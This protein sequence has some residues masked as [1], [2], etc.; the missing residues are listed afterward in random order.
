[1]KRDLEFLKNIEN[2]VNSFYTG[3]FSHLIVKEEAEGDFLGYCYKYVNENIDTYVIVQKPIN[4]PD[5]D[6]RILLHEY[7]HIYLGH[8]EGLHEELDEKL[9]NT[10]N[11]NK[12]ELSDYVN[13]CCGIDF[14]DKLLDRII[15]D[16]RLNHQIHNIAMDMEVNS[17][18]LSAEDIEEMNEKITEYFKS[19]D[20]GY[21]ESLKTFEKLK[22]INPDD[23]SD[24]EKEL[25]ENAKKDMGDRIAEFKVKLIHPQNY[26]LP[27]G[28]PFPS[29]LTYGEYLLLIIQNL[30]LF[31]KMLIS[32]R[33][34]GSGDTTE[35]TNEELAKYLSQGMGSL[36]DL[37]E[38]CGIKKGDH[39]TPSR[40][41]ADSD[42]SNKSLRTKARGL[43]GSADQTIGL[44]AE[45]LDSVD[46]AIEE[47]L[48]IYNSKVYKRRVEVDKLYNYNRGINRTTI[49]SRYL[50]K[51]DLDVNPQIVY[52]IDVSGSM[53]ENLVSRVIY[54]ILKKMGSLALDLTYS[55][56]CWNHE[57]SQEFRNISVTNPNIPEIKVNGGTELA[58]GIAYFRKNYSD[59][60][61]LVI[62][63]DLYDNLDAWENETSSMTNY[64]LYAL[65][66]GDTKRKIKNLKIKMCN[67]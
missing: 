23:L 67:D 48:T 33:L 21:L 40:E 25:L 2:F 18:V 47:I 1:M 43:G 34:G 38:N 7:G 9:I 3:T 8:L 44:I 22:Q 37:M 6:Y 60:N 46:K 65:N 41:K 53:N 10:I 15:D 64:Q 17:S 56:I 49:T 16:P 14:G 45:R 54:T 58:D 36:D 19:T 63:S 30:D 26:H 20:K 13:K 55:I 31:V 39:N 5:V 52:L 59:D 62:I 4:I 32:L 28:S 61:I 66:Y 50:T 29:D 35:V 42:R 27:D 11:L 51:F 12:V 24:E 57:L